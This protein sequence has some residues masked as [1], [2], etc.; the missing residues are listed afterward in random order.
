MT[1]LHIASLEPRLAKDDREDEIKGSG[2]RV[3]IVAFLCG[4]HAV[5]A[6][7]CNSFVE[8]SSMSSVTASQPKIIFPSLVQFL[9][10]PML[11][12]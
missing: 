7:A 2:A 8:C 11:L 3:D 10:V 12:T 4:R 5:A 1:V 6:S 9:L